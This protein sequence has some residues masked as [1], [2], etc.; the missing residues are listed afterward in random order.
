MRYFAGFVL[1]AACGG[2]PFSS[3]LDLAQPAGD[4]G[5]ADAMPWLDATGEASNDAGSPGADG[6]KVAVVDSGALPAVDSGVPTVYDS[7][8]L[9]DSGIGDEDAGG[10]APP[11]TKASCPLK[12]HFPYPY[13]VT[14]AGVACCDQLGN[15]NAFMVQFSTPTGATSEPCGSATPHCPAGDTCTCPVGATC[16][17]P[18]AICP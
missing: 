4:A 12:G 15:C 7:G 5:E 3:T 2:S 8:V 10:P 6:S 1:V 9:E 18:T 16:T 14:D 17:E 11:P 13:I